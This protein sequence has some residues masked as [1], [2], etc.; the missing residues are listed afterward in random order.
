[1]QTRL[2]RLPA[3]IAICAGTAVWYPGGTAGAIAAWKTSEFL[4]GNCERAPLLA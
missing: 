1:M 2:L 3:V 4:P